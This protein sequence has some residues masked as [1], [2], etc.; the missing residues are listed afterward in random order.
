MGVLEYLAFEGVQCFSSRFASGERT[1]TLSPQ[2]VFPSKGAFP[3]ATRMS[4]VAG[5]T[6]GAVRPQ[7]AESLASQVEG[8][9]TSWRSEQ[10]EFQT[11]TILPFLGLSVTTWP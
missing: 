7:I 2:F 10:S 3:V 9:I 1:R 8:W 5:S 11:P 6:T 4:P